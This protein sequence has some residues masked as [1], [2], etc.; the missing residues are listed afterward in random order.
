MSAIP[1][2]KR[3]GTGPSLSAKEFLFKVLVIGDYGVGQ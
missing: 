1:E 2:G 3:L